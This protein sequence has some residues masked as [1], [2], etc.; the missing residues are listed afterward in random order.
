MGY[1]IKSEGSSKE[2]E[3]KQI[4]LLLAKANQIEIS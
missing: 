4:R 3:Q 2:T 1:W